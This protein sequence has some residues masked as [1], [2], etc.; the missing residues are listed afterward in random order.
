MIERERFE[1][2]WGRVSRTMSLRYRLAL[3]S[4]AGVALALVVAALVCYVVV[5]HELRGAGR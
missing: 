3:V 1:S 5:R 4:A 2:S